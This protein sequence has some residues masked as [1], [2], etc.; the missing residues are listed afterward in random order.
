MRIVVV[1]NFAADRQESMQRF[2]DLLT[3]GLRDRGHEVRRL[4]PESRVAR[5]AGTY[6]YG[7]LPKYLGYVDKF[8]LFPRRL[9][10]SLA[11][12]P[13]DVVHVVD[14]ANAAYASACPGVPVLTTCHDLLQIRA[15]RGELP[16]QHVGRLG[17]HYQGWILRAIGRLDHAVCVSARTRDDVLRL[18]G[19]PA[20]RVSLI[21]NAL[22]HPYTRLPAAE[23]QGRLAPRLTSGKTGAPARPL[24]GN[25]LLNVGGGQWYKNRPGLLRIYARLRATLP[26]VP[27]LVLVGKELSAADDALLRALGLQ[28]HVV[29]IGSVTNAELEALYSL[30]EGLLFPSLEEG[31]GW[32]IAE[33]QACGCPVF[34]ANREP[35]REVGG[36]SAITFDPTDAEGAAAA[37]TAAWP[38][39]HERARLGMPEAGRWSPNL[40]LAAYEQVYRSLVLPDRR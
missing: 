27:P 34:T 5:L 8:L 4:R 18:S 10:R 39:R 17:R 40:M 37:I 15:A 29:M 9:R 26:G 1:G 36:R 16:A 12:S 2:A 19:L 35:M 20:E 33:A 14:H 24:P 31:F 11:G 21:H 32:P 7:G 22:N 23:A 38:S 25:Y 3:A 13:A 30:A 6:R 28:D